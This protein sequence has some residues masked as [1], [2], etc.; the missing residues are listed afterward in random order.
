MLTAES[1]YFYMFLVGFFFTAANFAISSISQLTGSHSQD[2]GVDGSTIGESE[3]GDGD[4]SVGGLEDSG[5]GLEFGDSGSG[6]VG[7]FEYGDSGSGDVGGFEF[8]DTS[9]S[10]GTG[11]LE[12]GNAG[13]NS[14]GDSS[15]LTP[16]HGSHQPQAI[17]H[18]SI[19]TGESGTTISDSAASNAD[20][21]S[22]QTSHIDGF[23]FFR[24]Y[25]TLSA[26]LPLRPTS[27]ICFFAVTGGIGSIGLMV[28]WLRIVT[29]IIAISSG[30]TLSMLLGVLLPRKL[31]RAQ[32]TSAA[33]RRE[34]IG[35]RAV[36]VSAILENGYGRISYVVRENSHSAPAKHIDGKRVPQGSV[37]AIC[38]I[39][40]NTFYVFTPEI[41]LTL[42]ENSSSHHQ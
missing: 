9:S 25:N 7:G 10:N 2:P 18:S 26:F 28:G 24:L 36:V 19:N 35:L 3:I 30:Y 21:P 31:I 6:D 15:L 4:F 12:F 22:T 41:S 16:Y 34:L 42:D 13:D 27:F 11:E 5:G 39:Q 37:V 29:H 38:K 23:S 8:G 40:N 14:I 1:I 32:N 20:V 17:D 33:E